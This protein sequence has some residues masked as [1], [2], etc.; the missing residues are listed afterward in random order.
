VRMVPTSR[1]RFALQVDAA[2]DL[3]ER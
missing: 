3:V 2:I 1:G